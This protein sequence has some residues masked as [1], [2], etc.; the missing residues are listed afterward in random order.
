MNYIL[1]IIIM[2]I[3]LIIEAV[4]PNFVTIWFAIGTLGA[5]IASVCG[6]GLWWQI[7]IFTVL[8]AIT[9]ILTKPFVKKKLKLETTKTNLDAVIGKT[10]IVTDSITGDKFAGAVKVA[11]KEWSAV[12]YECDILQGEKVIV[13]DIK[14]VKLV[15]EKIKET[16]DL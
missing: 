10:A 7:C 15:V 8:S 11:G 4:T 12:C 2:S 14:G 3:L 13:K 6:L 16:A 5:T 9:L 1:W